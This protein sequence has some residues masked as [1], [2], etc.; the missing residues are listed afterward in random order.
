MGQSC[1]IVNLLQ[2]TTLSCGNLNVTLSLSVAAGSKIS[3]ELSQD[4]QQTWTRVQKSTDP[5]LVI[6]PEDQVDGDLYRAMVKKQKSCFYTNVTKLVIATLAIIQNP[7]SVDVPPGD[8]ANFSALAIGTPAPQIQWQISLDQG[9]SWTNLLGE[10]N[11]TL[12]TPNIVS[13]LWRAQFDNG[14]IKWTEP[15]GSKILLNYDVNLGNGANF[16][17]Q[18]GDGSLYGWVLT[19]YGSWIA[20]INSG[21]TAPAVFNLFSPVLTVPIAGNICL[22]VN[23]WPGF[24]SNQ[25]GNIKLSVNGSDFNLISSFS[26]INYGTTIPI[27]DNQ[28]GFV[29]G[30]DG[31]IS[32]A[33]LGTFNVG[34]QIQIRFDAVFPEISYGIWSLNSIKVSLSDC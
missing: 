24:H 15:A 26:P 8:T 18:G 1:P 10:T 16:I 20:N 14:C 21:P 4:N 32:N 5:T 7:E 12:T 6:A 11:N 17:N 19:S 33:T 34:D 3:W 25:S 31:S 28:P 29:N 27:L 30:S 23:H 2:A 13:A 22:S 9:A